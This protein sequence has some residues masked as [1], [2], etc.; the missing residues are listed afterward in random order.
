MEVIGVK[1]VIVVKV[2]LEVIGV[3]YIR[4]VAKKF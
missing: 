4:K 1:K 3:T 2:V